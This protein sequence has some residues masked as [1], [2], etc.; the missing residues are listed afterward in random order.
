MDDSTLLSKV[1]Y[2]CIQEPANAVKLI[3]N[4]RASGCVR[5]YILYDPGAFSLKPFYLTIIIGRP[6]NII[7]EIYDPYCSLIIAEDISQAYKLLWA[8]IHSKGKDVLS[9]WGPTK[10]FLNC[11]VHIK[12]P[13]KNFLALEGNGSKQIEDERISS[14]MFEDI[15]VK[16]SLLQNYLDTYFQT[17][18][19]SEKKGVTFNKE[20]GKYELAESN[21]KYTYGERLCSYKYR[22]EYGGKK[23]R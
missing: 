19:A 3:K 6:G 13:L 7:D 14:Y 20:S 17:L 8:N 16:K 10:E 22:D 15:P 5:E 1:V 12:N 21:A 18:L 4:D 9:E 11:V 2:A 23:E